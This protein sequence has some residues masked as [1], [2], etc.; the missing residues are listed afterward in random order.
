MVFYTLFSFSV[1][2]FSKHSSSGMHTFIHRST[3]CLEYRMSPPPSDLCSQSISVSIKYLVLTTTM[4]WCSLD[5]IWTRLWAGPQGFSS[6]QEQI[7]CLPQNVQT[8]AGTYLASYPDVLEEGQLSLVKHWCHELTT[9]L[10]LVLRL[11]MLGTIP[12]LPL[13]SLWCT[14]YQ[15]QG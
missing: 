1:T 4:H 12:S 7:S 14:A 15:V 11:R 13:T 5:T 9:N 2:L 6:L 8:N 10:H 3:N